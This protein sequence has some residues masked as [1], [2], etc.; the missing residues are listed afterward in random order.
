LRA[1]VSTE[2]DGVRTTS[3][4]KKKENILLWLFGLLACQNG[5]LGIEGKK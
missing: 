1:Q 3:K 2:K 4:L 5:E